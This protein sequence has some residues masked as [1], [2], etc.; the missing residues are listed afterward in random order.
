MKKGLLKEMM[1][2]S[3]AVLMTVRPFSVFAG[4]ETEQ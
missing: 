4:E 1:K 2:I 3:L